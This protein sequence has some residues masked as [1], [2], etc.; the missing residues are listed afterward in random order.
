MEKDAEDHDEWIKGTPMADPLP[1]DRKAENHMQ[2]IIFISS[3]PNSELLKITGKSSEQ[4]KSTITCIY[5][6]VQD[7]QKQF[8]Q[9]TN[10]KSY[11][12]H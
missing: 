12:L 3:Y 2:F 6:T 11:I 9:A 8:L 7:R 10:R 4:F 1:G 5:N